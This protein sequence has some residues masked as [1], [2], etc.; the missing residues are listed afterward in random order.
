MGSIQKDLF[1]LIYDVEK[2]RK[3]LANP[4]LDNPSILQK[5]HCSKHTAGEPFYQGRTGSAGRHSGW[6]PAL[7]GELKSRPGMQEQRT[8]NLP[9]A[10]D[11]AHGFIWPRFS[12]HF[13]KPRKMRVQGGIPAAPQGLQCSGRINQV[14]RADGSQSDPEMPDP[15]APDGSLPQQ[16]GNWHENQ[17]LQVGRFW[18]S[19]IWQ[20]ASPC[21]GPQPVISRGSFLP[22]FHI[23]FQPSAFNFAEDWRVFLFFFFSFSL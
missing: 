5:H 14:D 6:T 4:N 22:V 21:A 23:Q 1:D 16:L 2:L 15:A 7:N 10:A 19:S 13:G 20:M 3:L 8:P 12:P 11:H 17:E 18:T 9:S